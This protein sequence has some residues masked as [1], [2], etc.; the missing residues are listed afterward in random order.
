M[1]ENQTSKKNRKR[2]VGVV[3][4]N[5]M[6]KTINVLVERTIIHPLFRKEVRRRKKFMAHD[7]ENQCGIGDR[8]LIEEHRPI[9]KL[10][11]WCVVEVLEKA[12]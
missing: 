11:R 5:K 9:S 3:T 1:T 4:S 12:K 8:V 2:R 10:K 6:D 7:A